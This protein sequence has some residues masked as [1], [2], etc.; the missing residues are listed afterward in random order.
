MLVAHSK[1]LEQGTAA[2]EEPRDCLSVLALDPDLVVGARGRSQSGRR[3]LKLP[4]QI[5]WKTTDEF[6]GLE[7]AVPATVLQLPVTHQGA[8][9][10]EPELAKVS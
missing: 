6:A 9:T 2:W 5:E 8:R 1:D 3:D 4:D 7:T 10:P